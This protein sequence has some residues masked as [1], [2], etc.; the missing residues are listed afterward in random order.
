MT[1]NTDQKQQQ[2]A[3]A[4]G[5][6]PKYIS[7]HSQHEDPPILSILRE[8]NEDTSP[9]SDNTPPDTTPAELLTNKDLSPEQKTQTLQRL[10]GKKGKKRATKWKPEFIKV[11]QQLAA[12]GVPET[13]MAALFQVRAATFRG[14]KRRYPSFRLALKEGDSMKRT[15]LTMQM[16]A[17]AASGIFQMQ[18]F[19]AKNWLGMTDR[20]DL[21]TQTDQPIIYKSYIPREQ[22][23]PDVDPGSVKRTTKKIQDRGD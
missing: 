8:E 9:P 17:T 18:M 23:R 3:P 10:W 13:D 21:R 6:K 16:Q 7:Q 5:Q 2:Q 22:G 11:A 1:D 4:G 19:L 15:N 12:I 14:W 20:Q